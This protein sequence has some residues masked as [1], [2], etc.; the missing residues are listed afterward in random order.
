MTTLT[1][2]DEIEVAAATFVQTLYPDLLVFIA[3]S[4]AV[5]AGDT[6]ASVSL[7]SDVGTDGTDEIIDS[8][9]TGYTE[10]CRARIQ[11]AV[12]GRDAKSI[13]AKV[14][15]IWRAQQHPALTA[16]RA[17]G[18]APETATG[19]DQRTFLGSSGMRLQY[20]VTLSGYHRSAYTDEADASTLV[21]AITYDLAGVPDGSPDLD[22]TYTVP[23]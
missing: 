2:I 15:A 10:H 18:L 22:V 14:R 3:S 20:I 11:V 16:V 1:D 5:A 12:I 9:R 7:L 21:T 13:A 23:P 19:P 8:G 6:W 4:G 17:L